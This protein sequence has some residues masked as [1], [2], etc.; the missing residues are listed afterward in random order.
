MT[1]ARY[2]YR[3]CVFTVVMNSE[4]ANGKGTG[5]FVE[6]GKAQE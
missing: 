3:Y 5:V 4:I 2:I 6:L 1:R